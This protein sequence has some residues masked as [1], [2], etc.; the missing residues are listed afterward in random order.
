MCDI[1]L[2]RFSSFLSPDVRKIYYTSYFLLIFEYF[3]T[4]CGSCS[5]TYNNEL[6]D[7]LLV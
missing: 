6:W 1:L 4:A 7:V 2:F 3:I 5:K